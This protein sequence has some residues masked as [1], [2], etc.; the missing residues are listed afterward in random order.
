M[1]I[2]GAVAIV[3]IGSRLDDESQNSLRGTGDDGESGD[4]ASY[5]DERI[6]EDNVS[7]EMGD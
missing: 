3:T 5:T 2:G 1:G 4:T 7:G 6:K